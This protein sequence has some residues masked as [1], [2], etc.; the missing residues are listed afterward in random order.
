M[1]TVV[2]AQQLVLVARAVVAVIIT[3]M[4]VVRHVVDV[5]EVVQAVVISVRMTVRLV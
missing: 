4:M 1:Q 2:F 5:P 3:A